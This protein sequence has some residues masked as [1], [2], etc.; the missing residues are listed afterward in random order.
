MLGLCLCVAGCAHEQSAPRR[1]E[2]APGVKVLGAGMTRPAFVDCAA[3]MRTPG[4]VGTVVVEFVVQAD[5]RVG[6]I[7]ETQPGD[8]AL[9]RTVRDYLK[10]CQFVPSMQQSRAVAVKMI[11]PFAFRPAWKPPSGWS[12]SP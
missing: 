3:P 6:E 12:R 11:V 2:C 1:R 5:G 10:S 7:C 8:P 4:A 9:V